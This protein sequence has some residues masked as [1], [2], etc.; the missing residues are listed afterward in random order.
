VL[1]ALTR[2]KFKLQSPDIFDEYSG[3]QVMEQQPEV[4]MLTRFGL[5][6]T[7]A[8]ILATLYQMGLSTAKA[9]SKSSGVARSDVYRV[10]VALDELGLVEKT[11]STPCK[12]SAVPAEDAFFLLMKRRVEETTELQ[13]TAKLLLKKFKKNEAQNA[14]KEFEPGFILVPKSRTGV[15]RIRNAI[16]GTQKSLDILVSWKRFVEGATSL[17]AESLKRA[18]DKNVNL[19]FIVESPPRGKTWERIIGLF[20]DSPLAEIRF[21]PKC[22][23]T[24]MGIYD[25]KEISLVIN[26]ATGLPDS[27]ALWSNC[28]SL[29][30]MAQ[31]YFDVLWITAMEN[32]N[33]E[34]D[35][36]A[37]NGSKPNDRRQN[38]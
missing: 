31:D 22:P 34:V 30:T 23:K 35:D 20:K 8:K 13:A 7:Q 2:T 38:A 24:V 25:K 26:P 14:P 16:E 36:Q 29:I 15:N 19:R 21:V 33:Y 9:I 11:V 12:Y 17:F 37:E 6:P 28:Q 4:S 32:P 5:S 1:F 27:P 10:I 3:C 18:K